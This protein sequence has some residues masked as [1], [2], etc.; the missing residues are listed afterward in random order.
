MS[1]PGREQ[2]ALNRIGHRLAAEDPRLGLRFAYFTRLTRHDA[3]P[4]TEQV[5]GRLQRFA[6][7]AVILPLIVIGLISLVAG[8]WLTAGRGQACPAAPNAAVS[9]LSPA[10]RAVRCQP[11]P[12]TKPDTMP[13]H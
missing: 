1:L 4:A 13:V 6:R 2:R 12:A 8:T 5:P 11:A 3:M 9:G 7:S 10:S